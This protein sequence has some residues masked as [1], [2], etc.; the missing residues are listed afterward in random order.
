MQTDRKGWKCPACGDLD[1][2][3][4][5]GCRFSPPYDTD[6]DIRRYYESHRSHDPNGGPDP[7]PHPDSA[8]DSEDQRAHLEW[9]IE[10]Y[11]Y[12][13]KDGEWGGHPSAVWIRKAL[14]A[15]DRLV[16]N[17]IEEQIATAP[18]SDGVHPEQLR[19]RIA[20]IERWIEER[21]A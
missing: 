20:T 3:H 18:F 10:R 15:A 9:L 5:A 11:G 19:D 16:I 6:D 21:S 12:A 13:R 14:Q 4:I 2:K 17:E 8:G 1:G 7:A